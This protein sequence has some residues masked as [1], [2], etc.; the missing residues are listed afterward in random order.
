[1]QWTLAVK[2]VFEICAARWS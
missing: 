1:M 2:L